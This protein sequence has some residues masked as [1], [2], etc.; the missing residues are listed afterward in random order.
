MAGRNETDDKRFQCFQVK[1]SPVLRQRCQQLLSFPDDGLGRQLHIPS[2]DL[3]RG[4]L[5]RIQ[6]ANR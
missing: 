3:S 2:T 4:M 1:G 5:A 6:A